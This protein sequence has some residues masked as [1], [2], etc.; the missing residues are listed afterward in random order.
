MSA[1][2]EWRMLSLGEMSVAGCVTQLIPSVPLVISSQP[3]AACLSCSAPCG[4]LKPKGKISKRKNGAP[5][6]PITLSKLFSRAVSI[7]V[8]GKSSMSRWRLSGCKES[9]SS[10]P[11]GPNCRHSL[12]REACSHGYGKGMGSTRSGMKSYSHWSQ[13]DVC[14]W[15]RGKPRFQ[16]AARSAGV[17]SCAES[18]TKNG[19]WFP[20]EAVTPSAPLLQL[21]GLSPHIAPCLLSCFQISFLGQKAFEEQTSC[22]DVPVVLSHDWSS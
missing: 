5:E 18:R 21:A 16:S 4:Q 14:H 17:L 11:E 10:A 6:T 9:D 15:L 2:M 22:M 7:S 3:K 13:W 1:G 20:D 12:G 8:K 19:S